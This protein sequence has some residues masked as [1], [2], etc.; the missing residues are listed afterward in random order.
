MFGSVETNLYLCSMYIQRNK[1]KGKN[2]KI[3][4]STLL[5]HKYR[6][7]GEIKTH[8][9]ANL[10]RLPENI[11]N[12][13]SNILKHGEDALVKFSDIQVSKVVD[14]GLI[15]VIMLLMNSLKIDKL[16]DKVVPELSPRLKAIIIGKIVTRGSK[17]GIFNWLNRN[18]F[19]SNKLE[20]DIKKLQ[21]DD[22][23]QALGAASFNQNKIEK[24]WFLY[25]KGKYKK[26]Y[27]YDITS[28][29]FEGVQNELSAFGYNRDGKK[30]KMQINIGLVTDID[31]IPLKIKVF[32]GNTTDSKTVEDELK[33]LKNDFGSEQLIFVGDRGMKIKYNLDNMQ[34]GDKAGIDYITGLE[35][36]EIEQLLQ[37]NVIQLSLFSKELAEVESEGNR[38]ILSE[39]PDLKYKEEK[40]LKDMHILC[41]TSLLPIKE[42]W[43]KRRNQNLANIERIKNGD[44]NKKLVRKFTQK[45]LDS[46][47]VRCARVLEKHKMSKYYTIEITNDSFN[48]FFDEE[49]FISSIRLAGKYVVTTS[50]P[51]EEMSK[52]EVRENYK[53]LSK[54]E[55]A[56]R[57]FKSENIQIRP[58]YH[59]NEH[60]TRGHVL[61]S[62]FSYAI[63]KEMENKI[64]PSLEQLNKD[65][66]AKLS[67]AD[68]LEEL[69]N[70]KMC[71]L[72]VP[73]SETSIKFSEL[74]KLQTQILKQFNVT[75]K[76]FDKQL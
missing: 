75:K 73:N 16:L 35:R 54:V 52:E 68:I 19:I 4:T 69:N 20:L 18:K 7:G 2:G 42:S 56:F 24:K 21:V 33:E 76:Q 44:K 72:K 70:I 27:L 22:L 15:L 11:I 31:G 10:S 65:R 71:E 34:E 30:G 12:S 6:E 74:N 60:Q 55:H 58:V 49:K 62:M 61:M 50:I 39:N 13:I 23:Y 29:Y 63:I 37:Q 25:N 9:L 67:F 28:T 46:Y 43:Q 36:K 38:Y 1:S 51:K 8:V 64:Y 26:I 14:Y 17:L 32:K 47:T 5:C 66:R 59:R 57:D 41:Q 40:F 48:V 53:S 45:K 3:Y